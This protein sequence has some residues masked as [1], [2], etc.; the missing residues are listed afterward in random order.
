MMITYK[1]K[2]N[3]FRFPK[4]PESIFP[5]ADKPQYIEKRAAHVDPSLRT[6]LKGMKIWKAE[7]L[8]RQQEVENALKNAEEKVNKEVNN[9]KTSNQDMT[10]DLPS[11][12]NDFIES[13]LRSE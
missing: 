7:N 13:Y 1:E 2:K 4:D 6:K 3:A 8:R 10:I 11:S 5:Q 12:N 9:Y